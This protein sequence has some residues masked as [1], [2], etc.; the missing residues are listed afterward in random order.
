MTYTYFYLH[1]QFLLPTP[2]FPASLQ[3]SENVFEIGIGQLDNTREHNYS[4]IT[5][6]IS[7][8]HSH[9]VLDQNETLELPEND[10]NPM[11]IQESIFVKKNERIDGVTLK[12]N[13]IKKDKFKETNHGKETGELIDTGLIIQKEN[14]IND[15]TP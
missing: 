9:K 7:V 13:N 8:Q 4:V 10:S 5:S 1:I 11:K 2:R 6:S 3:W 15:K 14:P 12:I